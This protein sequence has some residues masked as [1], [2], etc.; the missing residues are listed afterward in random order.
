M[1]PT[2]SNHH[3]VIGSDAVVRSFFIHPVIPAPCH[4]WRFCAHCA[5]RHL[6]TLKATVTWSQTHGLSK[7]H[8]GLLKVELLKTQSHACVSKYPVHWQGVGLL[9][10]Y[11]TTDVPGETGKVKVHG[12]Q[13]QKLNYDDDFGGYTSDTPWN[14]Q[15]IHFDPY[16][17]LAS[18]RASKV[19]S[20]AY[21]GLGCAH[22]WW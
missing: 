15:S 10:L 5:L 6:K 1:A 17:T 18:K 19:A 9:G 3:P 14:V 20:K 21:M 11:R 2:C 22:S 12:P 7:T 4:C 13:K 16:P 8:C